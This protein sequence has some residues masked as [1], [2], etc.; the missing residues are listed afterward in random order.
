MEN[1]SNAVEMGGVDCE[2]IG[3]ELVELDILDGDGEAG[4]L[5]EGLGEHV[6]VALGGEGV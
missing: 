5:V 4:G 6:C 3:C 1:G 2:V